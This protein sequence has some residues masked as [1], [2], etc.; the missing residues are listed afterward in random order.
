MHIYTHAYAENCT[1]M[2][3]YTYAYALEVGRL[4]VTDIDI[5]I[6]KNTEIDTDTIFGKPKN[7]DNQEIKTFISIFFGF[8]PVHSAC[9]FSQFISSIC[10]NA[11][12]K[13]ARN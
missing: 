5:A 10:C 6:F 4:S 7:T 12:M 3:M 13:V 1:H 8:Y 2:H 11:C 9:I